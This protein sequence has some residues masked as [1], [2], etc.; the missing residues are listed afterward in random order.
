ML[1]IIFPLS[2]YIERQNRNLTGSNIPI[3]L[4]GSAIGNGLVD[5][6]IQ[7][8]YYAPFA[9]SNGVIKRPLYDVM[10]AGLVECLPLI[11]LCRQ[12][13]SIGYLACIN[14]YDV[15]NLLELEPVILTGVNP[16]DVREKCQIRPLCYNFSLIPAYLAQPEVIQE[17]GVEGHKWR[18]CNRLT[19]LELVLAGDWMLNYA[20][21]LPLLLEAG[22]R[23]LVYEGEFDFM[24]NWLG[25]YAWVEELNWFGSVD[26]QNAVN[27]TWT[28][29]EEDAGS[30]KT[31]DG[32]TFLKVKNAGH[33]VP[34]NQPANALAMITSFFKNE[35]FG[36][37]QS[38]FIL[39]HQ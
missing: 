35:S 21:D 17:L 23:I 15:C 39:N 16:Y 5:P 25:A 32:L 2:A 28:V 38:Q 37:F 6:L 1:V 11:D 26:F 14:A 12:N 7:Y 4:V 34:M 27:T 24:C 9:L 3:N 18:E 36:I 29:N 19:D 33:M 10:E 20:N 8:K 13:S 30:F 31:A 22:H